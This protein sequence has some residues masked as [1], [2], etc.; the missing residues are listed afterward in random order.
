MI[1]I[2]AAIWLGLWFAER[3][4]RPVGRLAGAA[5][6]V[7]AGDLDIQVL[8]EEGDDEIAML[9]RLFNQMTKQ[10]K[11]QRDTLLDNTQQIE[12]RQILFDS[13]LSSVTGGVV[14]LDNEGQVAFVNRAAT[15]LLDL[16]ES[17]GE[18]VSIATAIPE[19]AALF[20]KLRKGHSNVAQEEIRMTRGSKLENL[21]VHLKAN[22]VAIEKKSV[23]LGPLL[24]VDR[25]NEC[26]KNN[27]AANR[28]VRGTY[29]SPWLISEV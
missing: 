5:Q 11:A 19:F 8:E 27:D 6:R 28:L 24:E 21:L 22:G 7:G 23:T 13:V 25:E 4:A 16:S 1:L 10:L 17:Q 18:N 2:L 26:F 15:R 9:S 20:D 12:E 3:L 14:G 29:R